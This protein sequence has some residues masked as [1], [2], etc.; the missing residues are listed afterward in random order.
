MAGTIALNDGPQEAANHDQATGLQT[1]GHSKLIHVDNIPVTKV[2]SVD[3]VDHYAV[4][5]AGSHHHSSPVIEFIYQADLSILLDDI[6]QGYARFIPAFTG[7]EDVAFAVLQTGNSLE[8][9]RRIVCASIAKPEKEEEAS[10]RASRPCK[11]RECDF[12]SCV[13]DDTQFGLELSI[14]A[15]PENGEHSSI[16]IVARDGFLLQLLIN[17]TTRTLKM[18]ITCSN[19]LIPEDALNQILRTA[20]SFL[21]ESSADLRF[22]DENGG[23][24]MPQLSILN[25]PPLI[26][27]PPLE[28]E[29]GQASG[30]SLLHAAFEFWAHA[31]PDA[32]ALDFVHSLPS[33]NKP[34]EHSI[35]TYADLNAAATRVALHLRATLE[36]RKD[37]TNWSRIIPVHMSTSPEL[38]ISYLGVL[39]AGY[40][41]CPIPQDAPQRRVQEILD[42]IGSPVILGRTPHSS[43]EPWYKN[44]EHQSTPAWL[45]VAEISKWKSLSVSRAAERQDA[46][47]YKQDALSY[48]SIYHSKLEDDIAY[49]IFTS[50]STGKPKGVQVTHLAATCSINSHATSIPLPRDSDGSFRWFQFASPTFDPSLMEI[51]VTFSCGATLCSASRDLTLTDLEAT[52][53]ETRASVMMATPSLAALLRPS[54]LD[55]LRYLWTMGEKLNR[56]VIENFAL[57]SALNGTT[58]SEDARS[59]M[60]VNA[61]GPTEG[62][63]NC[64]F[65][66]PVD[67]ATRGSI[68]GR[69][70]P[71]CS[72]FVLDPDRRSPQPV[73]AG[74]CGELAIGG[75]Q[76]SKGYLNRPEETARAFVFSPEYGPIYRTGDMARIVWDGQG[77]QVLEFLGR[78]TSDQVKISGKRLELGE[79]ESVLAIVRGIIE[80]VVIVVQR[81]QDKQGS[82]QLV[83]C[84]VADHS[85]G[86]A[87]REKL[88]KEC[89]EVAARHLPSYMCPSSFVFLESLPRSSSGKV[90]RRAI[91]AMLKTIQKDDIFTIENGCATPQ[92]AP[93]DWDAAG[94]EDPTMRQLLLEAIAKTT[95]NDAMAIQPSTSLFSLGIDSLGAMRLLQHLRENGVNHLSVSDVLGAGTPSGLLSAIIGSKGKDK[96]NVL[97]ACSDNSQQSQSLLTLQDAL[98]EF[99]R[100]NRQ[101]CAQRL[102]LDPSAIQSVLPTTATQSG[103]LASFLRRSSKSNNSKPAYIYHSVIHL[104][105][106]VDAERLRK[107]W[108]A[109]IAGYDSFRTVF[110]WLDDDMAPFAQCILARDATPNPEWKLYSSESSGLLSKEDLINLALSEAEDAITLNTPPWRMSLV[111]FGSGSA[112][113]L[114]MFHGIFDGGSLQL[115]LE[116]V[117]A[118][119][120]GRSR[121]HRTSLEHIVKHHFTAD[122]EATSRFW[123]DHLRKHSPVSFPSVTPYRSPEKDVFD[124][125]E[126]AAGTSYDMLKKRSRSMGCTPLSVLQAA[127]GSVLLSY[128]GTPEQDIIIGSVVSG[129]FDVDSEACI[130]PTFTTVPLRL[131]LNKVKRDPRGIL[132]NTSLTRHLTSLNA[133]SLAYLQPRL[134][135]LVTENGQLPYDTLLA[136]QD[137]NAGSDYSTL[138]SSVEHPPMANDFAVMVE[139]WP[140]VADGS[141]T[142]RSTFNGSKLEKDSAQLMLRQM[143]DIVDFILEHPDAD[144]QDAPC[145]T[146]QSLKSIANP[147]SASPEECSQGYLLHTQFE[148]HAATRPE[149]VALIFKTDLEDPTHPG[150]IEWS[151][152]TLNAKADSLADQLI[153]RYESLQNSTVPICI[154]KSPAMY[155]A[156]LGILKAGGAWC[157]IDTFSPPQRRRDLIARTGARVLLVSSADSVQHSNA[158]PEEIDVL[159]V[160]K[161]VNVWSGEEISP[162]RSH[163]RN[164]ATPHD[165]AYLIWTSG[166]TGAPKG[167]PI[168]HSAAVSS[169]HSLQRTIP[170]DVP[171]GVVRCLQFSQYTFDVSV[172]D[173]FYTWGLGGTLISAT[174]EIMLGC[175]AELANLTCA[176]HAHLTPAFAAGIP[177]KSCETLK[178]VT[179]IG[180]KLP[181]SVADDWGVDTQAFN[182]YGPA[183]VTV[184]STVREFGNEHRN[185]KSANIGWPLDSVSVFVTDDKRHVVMKNAVGELALGGPQL[186]D[187]YLNQEETTRSKFVWNEEVS[188]VLYYTGD[189]VRM[190]SDGSLEYIS[191][192]DDLVKLG[193]I[194]VE[195][196]EISFSIRSCNSLVEQVE[197][198]IL[199]RP[200]RPAE[201]VVAFLAAPSAVSDQEPD[202][203]VLCNERAVEIA[204]AAMQKALATLP[205]H[206]LPSV[207]LVVREIPKTQSAKTDRVALRNAYASVDIEEWESK[208]SPSGS[209][210]TEIGGSPSDPE[211]SFVMETIAALVGLP[212]SAIKRSNKLSSLGIDSIRAIRLASRLN[213]SGHHQ[214]SVIDVLHCQSVQD[215]L[216]IAMSS[217][218]KK[219]KAPQ[220]SRSLSEQFDQEWH[221]A[222]A[223]RV[224]EPFTVTRATPIQESLLSETM[225]TAPNMYWS[226]HFFSLDSDV[227]LGRLQMAWLRV[228]E[229]NEALR[230]GFIPVAE[231]VRDGSTTGNLG[232]SVLQLIYAQPRLDWE[233]YQCQEEEFTGVLHSRISRVMENHQNSYFR[234]PPWAISIFDKG[235]Q[236]TMVV[237]IHHAIH[238]GPSLDFIFKD[239]QS[240]YNSLNPPRRNQIQDA[241]SLIIPPAEEDGKTVAFWEEELREFSALDV[242]SWPDL[243]R[244]RGGTDSARGFISEELVLTVP[245]TQLQSTAYQLGVSSFTSILR[246]AWACVTLSY[247][248]AP[249]TV[250]GETLSDR[251]L[252]STLE[253]VMGPL[254]SVVPVPFKLKGTARELIAEQQRL[255]VESWK[256]RHIHPRQVRK[257]LMR[258]RGQALYPGLFTFHPLNEENRQPSSSCPRLW[259]ELDDPIGLNVEHLMALNV[260]HSENT[261]VLNIS[262]EKSV[263]D[264]EHL[265]LFVRQIDAFVTAMLEHPDEPATELV[266]YIPTELTSIST[267]TVSQDVAGAVF[268]SPTF[269]LEYYAESHPEWTA[270][271]IVNAI[272]VDNVDKESMSYGALDATAN[273]VAAYIASLGI[274]KRIIALCAGRTLA[275]YPIIAGIFKSGNT[276]LPIDEALPNDRKA[277]LV[278]DGDCPLIFT[279][280]SLA[281][282]FVDIPD[283]C[284][285]VLIDGPE[286]QGSLMKMSSIRK[287]ALAA[288]ED[289]SYLLYTSGS[290]GKPKGVLV[291]RGNLS[292]FVE[293]Q[294][295]FICRV[296][297]ATKQLGGSGKYLALASRAFDVHIAEIFLAWRHGLATVTGPRTMLLDDLHLALTK[298]EITHASFVPSL[299]DQANIVPEQCPRLRYLS[300]GGEKISQRVLDTWGASPSVALVNAYGPTEVTI[301]CS[302]ALVGSETNLRNIGRPLGSCVAHVLVPGTEIY[303]LRGQAGELCFTGDLVAKGYHNR[304]DVAGFVDNFFGQRMYRTGDI[305]RLMADDS[306]EYLGRGDDQTK[307][308]GQRLE[309]GE[310]SEVIRSSSSLAIDVVTMIA[311]HPSIAR[312]QLVSFVAR[313]GSRSEGKDGSVSFLE[314]DFWTLGRELQDAC[315][316][317]L[318]AYMV[319]EVVL[320]ISYV[321]LAPMSGKADIKQLQAVF[322]S[323]PLSTLV[324]SSSDSTSQNTA[325]ATLRINRPLTSAEEAVVDAILAVIPTDRSMLGHATNIFEIGLDSLSA[326]NL[327][328]ELKKLGYDATVA[329]VMNNPVIEQLARL[330]RST[331]AGN[332]TDQNSEVRRMLDRLDAQFRAEPPKGIDISSVSSVRPCLPLQEGLVAR[333]INEEGGQ[334]YVNHIVLE[335][336]A[337]ID[338]ARLRSAWEETARQNEILRTAFASL[339]EQIVQVVFRPDAHQIRWEEDDPS[340]SLH[341]SSSY[342]T[343]V[344]RQIIEDIATVP[345]IRFRVSTAGS[346]RHQTLTIAMHHSLYDGESLSLLLEEVAKRYRGE[347]VP[348]RGSPSAFLEYIYAQSVEKLKEFWTRL[349]EGC[350][351][352]LFRSREEDHL[353]EE[354]IVVHR[355]LAAKLSDLERCSASLQT[356]APSLVLAIF[357]LLLADMA[358]ASDITYGTVLSGR[359]V[360]VSGADSVLLP[361]ITTIPARLQTKGLTTV[362][363]VI[364]TVRDNIVRSL[365]F[366]HTPLRHIQRWLK[367]EAPLFDCL[368]SY[369]RTAKAQT[370]DLWKEVDSHMPADYP[371]AVEAEADYGRDSLHI[372][373]GY[374]TSFGSSHDVENFLEKMDVILSSVVMGEDISLDSFNLSTSEKALRE[375]KLS[376]PWNDA[377]WSETEMKVCQLVTSFC[378]LQIDDVSKSASFLGLGIDS[379]TAI[380]FA[381]KL[382][383]AGLRVSSSDVMRFSCVGALAARIDEISTKEPHTNSSV[384]EN[385]GKTPEAYRSKIPLL[386]PGDSITK[387]FRCTPLQSGMITQ[388]LAAGGAMYVHPHIVR[389][390][391][392]VDIAALK[393]AFLQVVRANDIL[394][395]SFHSISELG[396]SWIGAVHANPPFEWHELDQSINSI[397]I[398]TNMKQL[399]SLHDEAAFQFPPLRIY[400]IDG[401]EGK[402]LVVVMHHALYDGVSLPFIFDDVALAYGGLVPPQRPNFS[403]I[404]DDI[405]FRGQEKAMEF[406]TRKLRGYQIAYIPPLQDESSSDRM[407]VAERKIDLDISRIVERCKE[408]EVTVQTVSLLAFAKVLSCLIGQRDVVFGHVVAGRSLPDPDVER[409]IG[410]LFNTVPERICFDSKVLSNRAMAARIQ[411]ANANAQEYQHAPL[412]VIQNAVR[413]QQQNNFDS[414]SLFDAL[415]V[416]QKT[417]DADTNQ[418]VVPDELEPIWEP[419]E[420][421]DFVSSAEHTLNV[422]VEHAHDGIV[423]RSSC[424]GQYLTLD[425]LHTVLKDFENAF[426]DIIEHP[427]RCATIV[428]ERLQRL[429]L[430]VTKPSP[431]IEQSPS[432]ESEAPVHEGII[433]Q[434]LAEIA[435][436]SVDVIK[437]NTSIYSI[438]LDSIA[439]IRIAAICRSKGLK[440]GVADILKGQTLRG[441]S[442]RIS[443]ATATAAAQ[444]SHPTKPLVHLDQSVREAVLKQLQL[445]ETD[446]K[447]IIPC[448]SGQMYHLASWLKSGRTLF[449]PAWSYS[450]S[451]EEEEK[452]RLDPHRL[453]DAWARLRQRHPILRTCFAAISAS[454]AVQV[455]LKRADPD[456]GTFKFITRSS[457]MAIAEAAKAQAREEARHPSSLFRPPVRLR[458]LRASD[459]DGIL[460]LINHA[461]YDAWTMPMFVTELEELYRD[462]AAESEQASNPDFPS[463]VDYALRSLR[464]VDDEA[465]SYWDAVLQ[466]SSSTIIKSRQD[467]GD[468]QVKSKKNNHQRQQHL[469]VSAWQAVT[470]VST[471]EKTCRA[472]GLSLQSV[473]LLAVARALGRKT[474]VDSPTFG[475]YQTGRSASFPGIENLS[476]PCLNVTPFTVK[477]V[478]SSAAAGAAGSSHS[479][480]NS[481]TGGGAA[482]AT[483]INSARS[484]QSAL[485]DRVPYEQSSLQ[486]I[487]QRWRETAASS[488]DHLDQMERSDNNNNNSG[489][490]VEVHLFNTWV[491][492]L[493]R[494]TTRTMSRKDHQQGPR[495]GQHEESS[496]RPNRYA[497]LFAPLPIGVPTDFIPEEEPEPELEPERSTILLPEQEQQE[498]D[499][500][501]D[502][503]EQHDVTSVSGLETTYLPDQNVFIDIGPGPNPNPDS[504]SDPSTTTKTNTNTDNTDIDD[505]DTDTLGFGIRIEGGVM[506]EAETRAFIDEIAGEIEGMV[507][508]L[509][510]SEYLRDGSARSTQLNHINR[511]TD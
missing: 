218:K 109:V 230:A 380:Q 96:D 437:P 9:R 192:T 271:E 4:E 381:R 244:R 341:R 78:I 299:L 137:F 267:P 419:Y 206:M 38:Y 173:I 451:G 260:Y 55:T 314:T 455:V 118:E 365:E 362:R 412:R 450:V 177:R 506:D 125:V 196:S 404:V 5:A 501:D 288:P 346:S 475:L 11:I 120:D 20:A 277:F 227:D 62:A 122:H 219:E 445:S 302:S 200:D 10:S 50:G 155:V 119:Y 221:E 394:R 262:C 67:Q 104:R 116:D 194:R 476:G 225:G 1:N 132:S 430:Q 156:I 486:G 81:D 52:I 222:V 469:F 427:T 434:V 40:A 48:S 251:V 183:E 138:W 488:T 464:Q 23:E 160:T 41:F 250:F 370:H 352:T 293:A 339:G 188:Q 397:S 353:A 498:Q 169:M 8:T 495:Q 85:N 377:S 46:F 301:G 355:T 207:Y 228:A 359:A 210:A 347:D 202:E 442:A 449:E 332:K 128:T 204:R 212:L 261:L 154:E 72:M 479:L 354:A 426:Q 327:S 395:T 65:N 493:W 425:G 480:S 284:K 424:K 448:L 372:H 91:S 257:I 216:S 37:L 429:P 158:V 13:E 166:T 89:R 305:V 127:W 47:D 390:S 281:S 79:I 110:C 454:E 295:E 74:M 64:T 167:V 2:P 139:V 57:P 416:F 303:T 433:Q 474:H 444:E 179:M 141:L 203:L 286:F 22:A 511:S 142:L 275:S 232:F 187:G 410:P 189:V 280:A 348:H 35:L 131:A 398:S 322:A 42:D 205:D 408:M 32:V 311:K 16:S 157:P 123:N 66:A 287:D 102:H 77:Q 223:S 92:E 107:S 308:R 378:G 252:D 239:V 438:G 403:E 95:D 121:G 481:T 28:H 415:F 507:R 248:G 184:V 186:S 220:M 356:T 298:L 431:S 344:A 84:V 164:I 406:W 373:C 231:I 198:V 94:L 361:C 459:G 471:A 268:K 180:E 423:I 364:N 24:N 150:N 273:Q 18:S 213:Q 504:D 414:A 407:F 306:L 217:R 294:S 400:V 422:E 266:K 383:E 376:S 470:D 382:R 117:S 436:V 307:I 402:F 193:G 115:L 371:F 391:E 145:M 93:R 465:R 435:N 165:T 264:R 14:D 393:S 492:L 159:D 235:D 443:A 389:L 126:I 240:A 63:I 329:S 97:A 485:A 483:I 392:S 233:V 58:D 351:P 108:D 175:F 73:P 401:A 270:V 12:N 497:P 318:P 90:D 432:P 190:L 103:M 105:Q 181:Q 360:P 309:L 428:P 229:S 226:N 170:A 17:S 289:V 323:I 472:H 112:L 149:D 31:K 256:H 388:T 319:P 272:D 304:P 263:M 334:L 325:A 87:S 505:N 174:R 76:V 466:S 409:T 143:S 367:S 33:S 172:Q 242:P 487:L 330:P 453:K 331:E 489:G 124:A 452:K 56:T 387:L 215:L 241:F 282:T 99:D 3:T 399:L 502:E 106:D 363:E 368:F 349:F 484:I 508:I 490:N 285:L 477:N 310:V 358:D 111:D 337:D 86:E 146:S 54:R 499:K 335:L 317:K 292:A 462:A 171:G 473:V 238:D 276:Y 162:K 185:V 130:G 446:V 224:R 258:P 494:S 61:Y 199:N 269:W 279:E 500:Q 405:F 195:L 482:A 247:L 315:R 151:Y 29:L 254:I 290:T 336:S 234:H 182:T 296:A 418:G 259:S 163:S 342:R 357:A 291:T 413:K 7:L 491:N 321:P 297:P 19:R 133:K 15:P 88:V 26:K 278:A 340:M 98:R 68:I 411:Q 43:I 328:V 148:R 36:E 460:I 510:L 69:P 59:T 283:S 265:S 6:I 320:P 140:V 338:V 496:S 468:G 135:S 274:E 456:D 312:V 214:V 441:I 366:Q 396:F 134:G 374:T 82:E 25:F 161:L 114:S 191:R 467:S 461:A 100:R 345:P 379:V 386:G 458:H 45:N 245:V 44:A 333:S 39:K 53:N 197:T 316:K 34:A 60:L 237:T 300:V 463:F 168:K 21:K 243:T 369:V 153:Q 27:P 83:A 49:L 440:V 70:L 152:G 421:Q 249:A 385:E 178:V 176:T 208:V 417:E 439:A 30:P 51:F 478:L 136:F 324:Q 253:D 503:D 201:V 343:E 447:T 75:P 384:E 129:R 350:Q 375:A 113:I 509:S 211:E 420:T 144:F 147:V 101:I 313:S 246:T 255:S 326:I 236:R 457:E 71:T 80:I 209:D